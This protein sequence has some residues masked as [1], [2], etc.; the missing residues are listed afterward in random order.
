MN[1]VDILKEKFKEICEREGEGHGELT[2]EEAEAVQTSVFNNTGMYL[3]FSDVKKTFKAFREQDQAKKNR[4]KRHRGK[5]T[6][7][8]CLI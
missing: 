5:D 4:P 3:A 7:Q 8:L 2:D 1:I 6:N